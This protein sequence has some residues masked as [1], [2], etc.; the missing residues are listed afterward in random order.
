[1]TIRHY[2]FICLIIFA[3]LLATA[4]TQT[5]EYNITSNIHEILGDEIATSYTNVIEEDEEI[6]WE[7]Y[8]PE[9]YDPNDPPGVMVYISPQ[10]Q[11]KTPS[12]WMSIM[13]ESNLI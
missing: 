5:G 4:Q 6:T 8:V 2:I 7:I 11:I 12:G 3:P 10:N 13:E 9:N 1:M